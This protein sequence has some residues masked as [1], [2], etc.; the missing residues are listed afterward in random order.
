MTMRGKAM[1]STPPAAPGPDQQSGP[2]IPPGYKPGDYIPFADRDPDNPTSIAGE[3]ADPAR[4]AQTHGQQGGRALTPQE[5]Y[6]AIYG[7]DAPERIEYASWGR[8]VLGYLVDSF[9]GGVAAIPLIVGY[10]M[11]YNDIQ[12]RTDIHGNQVIDDSTDISNAAIG[13]LIF[14]LVIAIAFGFWNVVFRQGRT[15]YTLGKEAVGIRLVGISTGQPI[16]AGL[17][18]VRQL[19]HVLDN[20]ACY[21]GWLW[22][23]WDPKNQTLADKVMSTVVVIMPA[24]STR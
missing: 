1:S 15:G 22:P 13:M 5:Q 17:S 18:F 2:P 12:V 16:G 3:W 10:W 20:L 4:Q 23:L 24:E 7:S 8:R 19:A 11:I 9:L 14:G 21:L 6:R